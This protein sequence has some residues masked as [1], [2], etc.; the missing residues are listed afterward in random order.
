MK[1]KR[2]QEDEVR[3]L[4]DMIKSDDKEMRNLAANIINVKEKYRLSYASIFVLHLLM[5]LTTMTIMV[6]SAKH[7]AGWYMFPICTGFVF[8]VIVS[9]MVIF[10]KGDERSNYDAHAEWVSRD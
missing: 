5:T 1:F 7:G 9:L 4:I 3:N 10:S 8:Q 2:I 6:F